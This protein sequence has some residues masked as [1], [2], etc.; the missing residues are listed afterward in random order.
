MHFVAVS[1]EFSVVADVDNANASS[2]SSVTFTCSTLGGPDNAFVW[3]RATDAADVVPF[4]VPSPP[5]NVSAV[6]E[7]LQNTFT[8]LQQSSSDKYVIDSVN[9]TK[10]G[11]VYACVAINVAGLEPDEVQLLVQPTII[12][13]PESVLTFEGENASL[14]C[15]ADSFPLPTYSWFQQTTE[16]A[17]VVSEDAPR[18]TLDSGGRDL[19]FTGIDYSDAGSYFCRATSFSGIADSKLALITG[20]YM[21]MKT[22]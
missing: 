21:Y 14:S 1:P 20:T 13:Q 9:A 3:I 15:Q 5:L 2:G 19:V 8:V 22:F 18:L 10:N 7:L 16:G 17:V 4:S 11:G 6:V 12:G